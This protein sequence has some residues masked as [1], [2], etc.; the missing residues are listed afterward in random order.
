MNN[1]RFCTDP[2]A[3][4]DEEILF[5]MDARKCIKPE[6]FEVVVG[7]I[8]VSTVDFIPTRVRTKKEF[9]LPRRANP[10][11]QNTWYPG[12]GRINW[13]ESLTDALGRKLKDEFDITC[14]SPRFV[15]HLSVINPKSPGRNTWHS[16]LHL[17]EIPIVEDVVFKGNSEQREMRWFDAI[18]PTWPDPTKAALEMM[19]FHE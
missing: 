7:Q 8:T 14:S 13:G 17:F 11:F 1:N 16:I 18:N 9:L 10:P 15:G 5:L 3:I 4:S 2:A 6:I 19:G 12:G